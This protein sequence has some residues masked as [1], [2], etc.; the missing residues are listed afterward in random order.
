MRRLSEYFSFV[1]AVNHLADEQDETAE[2][3]E[4]NP[5]LF[6]HVLQRDALLVFRSLCKLSMKPLGDGPPDPKYE[7]CLV[8]NCQ[9]CNMENGFGQIC[10]LNR[11]ALIQ[12]TW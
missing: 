10:F 3:A 12:N 8:H 9:L 2:G 11:K 6:C 1:S 7:H 4:I 5:E